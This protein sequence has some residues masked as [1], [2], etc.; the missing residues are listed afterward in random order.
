MTSRSF[1]RMNK[2]FKITKLRKRKLRQQ[3]LRSSTSRFFQDG[4][5][6]SLKYLI[7]TRLWMKSLI[8]PL[9]R[10]ISV[11]VNKTHYFT[12]KNITNG[13]FENWKKITQSEEL[14]F[15]KIDARLFFSQCLRLQICL[16]VRWTKRPREFSKK[17]T[18]YSNLIT[19][20]RFQ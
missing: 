11:L 5:I 9:L 1:A 10:W 19:N 18:K 16:L 20:E 6:P 17:F 4:G 8:R 15:R 13:R 2:I 14:T 3:I 7:I 12:T